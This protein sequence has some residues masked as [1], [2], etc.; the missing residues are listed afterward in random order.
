ME[1]CP[2][3]VKMFE[4]SSAVELEQQVNAWLEQQ[5]EGFAIQEIRQSSAARHG[6]FVHLYTISYL[7]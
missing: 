1:K 4:A 6:K 5:G 3:R 2:H 7:I